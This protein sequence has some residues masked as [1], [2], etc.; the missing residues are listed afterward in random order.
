MI[1]LKDYNIQKIVQQE[2]LFTIFTINQISMN[3]KN[4]LII[5]NEI[6]ININSSNR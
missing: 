5:M 6:I 1:L 4:K 2:S 3:N